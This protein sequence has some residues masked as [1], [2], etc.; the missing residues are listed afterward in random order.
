[1]ATKRKMNAGLANYLANKKKGTVVKTTV[2]VDKLTAGDMKDPM[3]VI[4]P[5]MVTAIKNSRK[6]KIPAGLAKYMASKKGKK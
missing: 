2:K 1:M 6:G 5:Q 3:G 4:P